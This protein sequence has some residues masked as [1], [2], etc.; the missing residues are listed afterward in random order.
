[1]DAQEFYIEIIKSHQDITTLLV[2][3]AVLLAVIFLY[4][5]FR[6]MFLRR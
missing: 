3:T 1:M 2:V 6:D 4:L 5:V